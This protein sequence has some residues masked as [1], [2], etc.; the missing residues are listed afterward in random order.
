VALEDRVEALFA[1]MVVRC[2]WKLVCP[3]EIGGKATA[4]TTINNN[5]QH[6]DVIIPL[7][8][9]FEKYMVEEKS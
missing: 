9:C 4:T 5:R 3:G 8:L 1:F 6:G 7:V 2:F